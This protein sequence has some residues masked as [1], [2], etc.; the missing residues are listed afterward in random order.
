MMAEDKLTE[1]DAVANLQ[2][3]LDEFPKK[4]T[5]LG[6]NLVGFN[7]MLRAKHDAADSSTKKRR[8]RKRAGPSEPSVENV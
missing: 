2:A 3:Q 8:G 4:G 5:S 6:P 7:A 1:S